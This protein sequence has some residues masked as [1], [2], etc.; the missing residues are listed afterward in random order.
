MARIKE[1]LKFIHQAKTSEYLY[2]LGSMPQWSKIL[3]NQ[4]NGKSYN[5]F[6]RWIIDQNYFNEQEDKISI[7]KIAELS[8]YNSLKISKWLREIYE[9]IFQLNEDNPSLFYKPNEVPVEL[10]FR[11]FDNHCGLKT[12]LSAPPRIYE[13]FKFYFVNAKMGGNYFWVKDIYHHVDNGNHIIS[14]YL[15][16][17]VLNRYRE[18]AIAKAEF[19]GRL[20]Y[21]DHINKTDWEI[22]EILLGRKR[23]S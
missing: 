5:E 23:Y 12:S 6:L 18:F 22:D 10:Y 21:F 11:Y 9:S 1:R 17:G 13:K 19:E 8:G 3:L 16:G 4:N 7:K 20:S 2:S 14:I 15:Q